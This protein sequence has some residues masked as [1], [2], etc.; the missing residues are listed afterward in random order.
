[1]RGHDVVTVAGRAQARG[2]DHG[3][4]DGTVTAGLGDHALDGAD[5]PLHRGRADASGGAQ[6]LAEPRDLGPVREAPPRA[7]RQALGEMELDGVRADVDDRVARAVAIEDGRQ[8]KS[9]VL[10]EEAVQADGAHRGQDRVRILGLDG[11]RRC[12]PAV[13]GDVR[14]LGRAAVDAIP[15]APL[16]HGDRAHRVGRADDLVEELVQGV[17]GSLQRPEAATPRARRTRATSSA[18]AG[19]PAF[20]TGSQRWRPVGATSRRT[21]TSSRPSR[22]LTTSPPAARR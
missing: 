17:G 2:P 12:H 1:M 22:I 19:K 7:V 21:F 16:V 9:I 6:V 14:D 13:D 10:V 3:D 20:M 15:D 4:R 5:R 11:D 8:A 18:A